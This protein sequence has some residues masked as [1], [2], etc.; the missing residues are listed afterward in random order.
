VGDSQQ[1]ALQMRHAE[2]RGDRRAAR[3]LAQEILSGSAD[4]G[5]EASVGGA[6]AS[7]RGAAASDGGAFAPGAAVD[8]AAAAR[9]EATELL[10]RT[11]PDAFLLVVGLLGLGATVWL[12][13]NYIL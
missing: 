10:A 3:A 6:E 7:N 4:G 12:V 5:A 8:P 1:L 9:R 13:Y 11:H 2:E